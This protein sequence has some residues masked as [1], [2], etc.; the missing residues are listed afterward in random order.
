[1]IDDKSKIE[2]LESLLRMVTVERDEFK[3]GIVKSKS[4]PV[5]VTTEYRGVFFGYA[6]KTDGDII[7]LKNARLCLYWSADI[8]GFMGLAANGPSDNCR[9]GP[10]ADIELRKVTAVLEITPEAETKW[11]KAPFKT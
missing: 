5:L 7:H 10:P 9:I 6:T 1:M 2:W 8:K 4:R 11:L 3:D